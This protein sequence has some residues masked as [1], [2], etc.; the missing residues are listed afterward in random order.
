MSRRSEVLR[1]RNFLYF[2]AFLFSLCLVLGP[3]IPA[4]IHSEPSITEQSLHLIQ[5]TQDPSLDANGCWS[6]DGSEIIFQTRRKGEKEKKKSFDDEEEDSKKEEKEKKE[7]DEKEKKKGEE[8]EKKKEEESEAAR[9]RDIWIMAADGSNPRQ[10]TKRPEDEYGPVFSPD[11][12]KILFV[13]EERGSRD[14]WVM[15]RD[16]SHKTRLTKDKG[17]EQHPAWS[18][19]GKKIVYSALPRDADNFDLWV[20]EADGSS[21]IQLTQTPSNEITPSW[22][23][24]GQRIAFASDEGDNLDIYTIDTDGKDRTKL[25][26]TVRHEFQPAWSPDGSKIAYSAWG[27]EESLDQSNIWIANAD[28]SQ[29]TQ[30]TTTPPSLHPVWHPDGTKILFHSKRSGNWDLWTLQVPEN[31]LQVGPVAQLDVFRGTSEKDMLRLRNGE[32]LAGELVNGSISFTSPYFTLNLDAH[33]LTSV[34]FEGELGDTAKVTTSYGDRLTGWI[35]EKGFNF[36]VEG[37]EVKEFRKEKVSGIGFR[38]ATA[39]PVK[40]HL[41]DSL[42]LR[43]G[44]L[45]LGRVLH[46]KLI[47]VVEGQT[48][49]IPKE[50][51]T[52]IEFVED[53]K[54]PVK[55]TKQN[56]EVLRGTW[57]IEDIK[58][59]MD[60]GPYVEIF[61]D[62]IKSISFAH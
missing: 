24:N 56:G 25:I 52:K 34:V 1:V 10:L 39:E 36:K 31:L 2:F 51:V 43:N 46:E 19:D 30:L 53:S 54:S 60:L 61:K 17:I 57:M 62:K 35:A 37:G 22:H 49:E 7:K 44:D 41:R 18:P 50:T 42:V 33:R 9:D 15:D 13:S 26:G 58:F 3:F 47:M 32:V 27:S 48:L 40:N 12:K 23:P 8:K 14:I 29:Q 20:M 28:G 21:K 4:K 55:L 59:Q 6:P 5:L 16:G 11:G 38:I 45:L